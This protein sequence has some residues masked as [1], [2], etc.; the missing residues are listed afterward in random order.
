MDLDKMKALLIEIIGDKFIH[1]VSICYCR[2]SQSLHF[3]VVVAVAVVG[4]FV[5]AVVVVAGV[6]VN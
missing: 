4:V 3:G 2:W 1:H 5:V 6:G